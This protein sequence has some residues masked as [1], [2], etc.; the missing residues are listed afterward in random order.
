METKLAENIRTFRKQ[1]SLTQEQLAEVLGVTV[2]A[3]HKWE[4]RLSTPELNLITEMAD[5]FDV[6]VDVLLGHE[7]RDNRLQATVSRLVNYLNTENPE[8]LPAAEKALKRFPNAFDVVYLGALSYMLF[9]GK[10]KD[11]A[12]LVRARELF[13]KALIILP[14]SGEQRV[15]DLGIYQN[16]SDTLT[17]QGKYDESVELLKKH[18]PEGIYDANIGLTLSVMCKKPDDAA[19]F[20][21]SALLGASGDLLQAI[22]GISYMHVQKGS[23]E[24]AKDILKWGIDFEN[25]AR[26][27]GQT[28]VVDRTISYLYTFLAF[29]ELRSGNRKEA[30]AAARKAKECASEFDSSPNFDARS[31]RFIP[32][33]EQY[34]MHEVLGETATESLKEFVSMFADADMTALW[35]EI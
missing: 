14:Q 10:K 20:L 29:A 7:M 11:S 15:T 16:I 34:S 9:G 21:Y 1:K 19:H 33:T 6:S 26:Q 27:Q 32:D 30:E 24:A 25:G 22:L 2:G 4:T 23:C 18:N 28:G 3:V 13:E 5:F 31:F 8:G 12:M 17:L 35:E